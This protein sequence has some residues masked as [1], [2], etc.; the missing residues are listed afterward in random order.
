MHDV[1]VTKVRPLRTGFAAVIFVLA[2]AALTIQPAAGADTQYFLNNVLFADGGTA[3]GYVLANTT[4]FTIDGYNIT[5]SDP[6]FPGQPF[7]VNPLT[8]TTGMIPAG[9]SFAEF[10][11][12]QA[13]PGGYDLAISLFLPDS[14]LGAPAPQSLNLV[15][16]AAAGGFTDTLTDSVD[17]SITAPVATTHLISGILNVP[18]PCTMILIVSGLIGM[19]GLRRKFK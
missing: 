14:I 10:Q 13:N 1:Q 2:F 3:S 7:F 9:P 4:A 17:P 12:S 6:A 8:S 19:A 5:V 15:A 18:E 16:L 11:I